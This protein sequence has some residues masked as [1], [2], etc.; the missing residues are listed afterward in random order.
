M[1]MSEIDEDLVQHVASLA[2]L[3]LSSSEVNSLTEELAA[4]LAH[5]SQLDAVSTQDVPATEYMAVETLRF[6]S[7]KP[8]RCLTA[9]E[10]MSSAPRVLDNGFAVPTFVED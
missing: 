4:I 5:V 3:E 10:S 6:R 1:A 9:E 2:R 7:D 8:H